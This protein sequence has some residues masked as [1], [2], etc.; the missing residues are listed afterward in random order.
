MSRLNGLKALS[1]MRNT[2]KSSLKFEAVNA[3]SEER[4]FMECANLYFIKLLSIFY[5]SSIYISQ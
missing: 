3:K 4:H 2:V 1:S 5:I